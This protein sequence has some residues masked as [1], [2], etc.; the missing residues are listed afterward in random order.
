MIGKYA[1]SLNGDHYRGSFE[2]REEAVREAFYAASQSE[3]QPQTVYVGRMIQA[4]PKA[5]GHARCVISHMQARAREQFGDAG[6]QY[7][8][9][10]NKP[11]IE[12]LDNA[13]EL[14]IRGWLSQN[15]LLPTF[16]KID[17]IGEYPVPTV[18]SARGSNSDL[19]EVHEIGSGD[20]G[21]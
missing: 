12:S 8:V 1:F 7:L 3:T 18:S 17:A 5:D 15:E 10:L 11:Q 16:F 2:T 9:G 4:D 19:R 13:I 21:M 20:Y 6:S 14:A